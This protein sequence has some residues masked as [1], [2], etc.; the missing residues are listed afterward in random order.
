MLSLNLIFVFRKREKF[1]IYRILQNNGIR[2]SLIT[3][4]QILLLQ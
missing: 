1:S 3:V 4:H 2:D